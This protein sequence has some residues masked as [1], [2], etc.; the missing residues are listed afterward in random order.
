MGA[1]K[2]KPCLVA[3]ILLTVVTG[4]GAPRVQPQ[5]VFNLR[6][7]ELLDLLG[8]ERS[9]A[10]VRDPPAPMGVSSSSVGED[11]M[12]AGSVLASGGAPG[13]VLGLG[14]LVAAMPIAIA[15]GATEERRRKG[16]E[17][18]IVDPISVVERRLVSA[19]R[20]E[21]G[22]SR[23]EWTTVTSDCGEASCRSALQLRL[24]TIARHVCG[25]S[26]GWI[27]YGATLAVARAEGAEVLWQADCLRVNSPPSIGLPGASAKDEQEA[28]AKEIQSK[29]DVLAGECGDQLV[30][31][32]L[33]RGAAV[34]DPLPPPCR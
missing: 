14:V 15:E 2:P 24:R 30:T 29:F 6:R 22:L 34:S 19:L 16:M 12:G 9:V 8:R 25:R 18:L 7:G 10:M 23:V 11:L 21:P 33:G 5:R 20:A 26:P 27:A 17:P 13:G 31:S 28:F 1:V 4:C 32:L 3:V